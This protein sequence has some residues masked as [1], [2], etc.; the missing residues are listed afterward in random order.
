MSSVPQCTDSLT[1]VIAELFPRCDGAQKIY[2]RYIHER[3]RCYWLKRRRICNLF[4]KSIK[5]V[6][7]VNQRKSNTAPV[8]R[9]MSFPKTLPM[10][11][12][13]GD[14]P[15]PVVG[16]GTWA[17]DSDTNKWCYEATLTALKAG[18]RHLDCAW[19]YRVKRSLLSSLMSLQTQPPSSRH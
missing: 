11:S 17:S 3:Q 2:L 9:K 14:T 6:K 1:R 13:K 4:A 10:K 7:R 5:K 19:R 16:F 12:S 8:W 18:Y 15:V